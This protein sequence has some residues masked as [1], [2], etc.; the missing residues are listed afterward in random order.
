METE[1]FLGFY[2]VCV[3]G[4]TL[5]PVAPNIF[6]GEHMQRVAGCFVLGLILVGG[7]EEFL[8]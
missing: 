3:G 1:W 6:K 2:S 8:F 5:L 4:K 7:N